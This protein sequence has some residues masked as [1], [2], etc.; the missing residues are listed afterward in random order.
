MKLVEG[1][2]QNDLI[3]L[4]KPYFT[5]KQKGSGLGL[6]IVNKIINAFKAPSFLN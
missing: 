5:T 3:D 1:L 4:I 2:R 6:S